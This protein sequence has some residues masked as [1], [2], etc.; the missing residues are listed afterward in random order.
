M[1]ELLTAKPPPRRI[2][3]IDQS[4][5]RERQSVFI[6]LFSSRCRS[7]AELLYQPSFQQPEQTRHRTKTNFLSQTG[8]ICSLF[9]SLDFNVQYHI[10]STTGGEIFILGNIYNFPIYNFIL[11]H[12]HFGQTWNFQ[13]GREIR[14]VHMIWWRENNIIQHAP[15]WAGEKGV[16]DFMLWKIRREQFVQQLKERRPSFSQSNQYES[17]PLQNPTNTCVRFLEKTHRPIYSH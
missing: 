7:F 15:N 4:E 16:W 5:N 1:W 17:S 6:T 14:A 9:S 10:P 8:G 11:G 13:A 12:I 3:M 2:I